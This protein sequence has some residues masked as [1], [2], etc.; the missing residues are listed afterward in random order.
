MLTSKELKPYIKKTMPALIKLATKHFNAYIRARDCQGDYFPCISCGVTKH[1]ELM[2]AGHYF[3][4]GHNG[5]VRFDERN[6]HGQCSACNTHL[7]GNLIGYT[8]GLE[9]KIGKQALE[10]LE[11]KSQM[12]GF[13]WDK[14][15]LIE[16][17]IT[18]K[19]KIKDHE[20]QV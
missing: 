9:R 11:Q 20:N 18:Y 3:A 16:T 7:H 19:Q 10:E 14:F 12:R 5:A 2:H 17:I 1:K 4:A 6:V 15:A 8:N 13:Y